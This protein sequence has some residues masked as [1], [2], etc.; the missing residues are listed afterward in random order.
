MALRRWIIP[1]RIVEYRNVAVEA[2]TRAEAMRLFR[3]WDWVEGDDVDDT[4]SE[5]Y[6]IGPI[7]PE[8]EEQR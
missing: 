4:K 6:K 2:E 7:R 8:D 1:A 3:A 5:V